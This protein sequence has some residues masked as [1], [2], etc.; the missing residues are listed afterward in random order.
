M[1]KIITWKVKIDRS[2]FTYKIGQMIF[3][4][5]WANPGLFFVYFRSFHTL[6]QMA[7]IQFEKS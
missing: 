2:L 3:L 5:K 4:K 7:I 6:I 1:I